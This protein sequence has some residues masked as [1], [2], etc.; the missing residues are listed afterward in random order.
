MTPLSPGDAESV[1]NATQTYLGRLAPISRLIKIDE[2]CGSMILGEGLQYPP[3]TAGFPAEPTATVV[4][5]EKNKKMELT[6]LSYRPERS[7]WR[8]L[9]AMTVLRNADGLGGALSLDNLKQGES[10]DITVSCFARNQMT[11]VDTAESVHHIPSKMRDQTGMDAYNAEVKIAEGIAGKLGWAVETYRQNVDGAWKSRA[12]MDREA[13]NKLQA[14]AKINY[15]T[16]VEQSLKLLMAHIDA[17]GTGK[18]QETRD[19]WRLILI[20]TAYASYRM[21]CPMETPRQ[22]K[23]H[24]LGLDVF[25]AKREEAEEEDGPDEDRAPELEEFG[26]AKKK[27]AKAKGQNPKRSDKRKDVKSKEEKK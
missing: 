19:V 14:T 16:K 10:C 26:E 18:E 21:A 12:K 5:R 27:T 20:K 2:G 17:L 1:D 9:G 6:L 4:Q 23:A 3:F 15:W 7:V 25:A 24:A 22:M 8:E 11:I 13:R